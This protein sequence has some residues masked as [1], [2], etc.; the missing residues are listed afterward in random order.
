MTFLCI[1]FCP[2]RLELESPF[3][4][5]R[6]CD[7]VRGPWEKA[8]G[9]DLSAVLRAERSPCQQIARKRRPHSC[10]CKKKKKK[11]LLLPTPR[12]AWDKFF[13]IQHSGKNITWPTFYSLLRPQAENLTKPS[14]DSWPTE[15]VRKSICICLSHYVD[16][17]FYTAVENQYMCYIAIWIC[18]YQLI[19]WWC[20]FELK[21]R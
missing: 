1:R 20:L 16:L 12:S 2:G 18:H 13:P 7:T 8:N 6:R 5:W 15:T 19:E 4:L 10:T 3:Q 9:K 14:L 17:N 21:D 11:K